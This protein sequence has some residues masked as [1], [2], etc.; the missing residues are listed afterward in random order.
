MHTD[1]QQVV[2]DGSE[3]STAGDWERYAAGDPG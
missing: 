2:S 3:L 1:R